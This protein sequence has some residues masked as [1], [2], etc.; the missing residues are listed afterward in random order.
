M[1]V[2]SALT[3]VLATAILSLTGCHR[4][5]GAL[6]AYTGG[7]Y[8]YFSY[9]T[10]PKTV[11]VLDLRT[12]EVVFSMDVPVGKQ[13]TIEFQAGKGDDPVYSPDVMRYEVMEMGSTTG[14]LR[15]QMSVPSATSRNGCSRPHA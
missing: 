12:N 3:V 10:A 13:L 6:L 9:E 1:P 2:K 8:T 7:S 5:Q 4:P 15:N 11:R 14:K